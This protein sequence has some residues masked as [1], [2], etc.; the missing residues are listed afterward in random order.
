MKRV[1]SPLTT[2]LMLAA[3]V[4]SNP[5]ASYSCDDAVD[6]QS[7]HNHKMQDSMNEAD[8]HAHHHHMMMANETKHSLADY[9]LPQVKFVRDDGK[10]ISLTD[11]LNDGRPVIMNFIFTSCTT[12]CPVASRTFSLFQDGLGSERGKVHIVSISID[13]E[14]DT[15]E[16]LKKYA[17]KYGAGSE[18][19]FYTGTTAASIAVQKAFDIYRGDKMTQPP[20]TMLRA[21]PGKPW[22]RIDGFASADELL[23]QYRSLVASE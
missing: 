21:A 23:H 14:Q 8:P 20:V 3:I 4:A 15:P 7:N 19:H 22:M 17:E 16:V 12:I 13:P 6:H 1:T 5:I 2:A 18:W 11:E 9:E 10:S